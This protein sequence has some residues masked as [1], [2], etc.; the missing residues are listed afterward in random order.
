MGNRVFWQSGCRC[1]VRSEATYT[2]CLYIYISS[3]NFVLLHFNYEKF[4]FT[5]C[6]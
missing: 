1:V 5:I 6:A 4:F 2:W 3:T